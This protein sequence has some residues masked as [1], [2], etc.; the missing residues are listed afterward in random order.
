M[1]RT[2]KDAAILLGELAEFDP[3]DG[4]T[5]LEKGEIFSDYTQFLDENGLTGK[6]IGIASQMIPSNR[7]VKEVFDKRLAPVKR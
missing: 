3:N 2:V 7:K 1:A 6:R 4:E 5:H